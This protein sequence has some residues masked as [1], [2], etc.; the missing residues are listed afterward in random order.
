MQEEDYL[1]SF[2]MA[3]FTDAITMRPE[4]G[5]GVWP[6]NEDISYIFHSFK[7]L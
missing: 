6:L 1:H 7:N 3:E 5:L 2:K 4:I